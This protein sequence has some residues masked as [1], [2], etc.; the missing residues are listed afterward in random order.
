MKAVSEAF[1]VLKTLQTRRIIRI[2]SPWNKFVKVLFVG[3][4]LIGIEKERRDQRAPEH[5]LHTIWA[6]KLYFLCGY[7]VTFGNSS[8]NFYVI[9]ISSN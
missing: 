6:T 5:V 3:L 1:Q 4:L 2:G 9:E 8:A 7:V